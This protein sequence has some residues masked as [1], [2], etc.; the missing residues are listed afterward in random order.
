[1]TTIGLQRIDQRLQLR[2]RV[3][4]QILAELLAPL[5]R[6]RGEIIEVHAQY[7]SIVAFRS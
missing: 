1:M 3:L 5:F 4:A 2:D 7:P 6:R